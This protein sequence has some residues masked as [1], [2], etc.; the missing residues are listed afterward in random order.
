MYFLVK[1]ADRCRHVIFFQKLSK[2]KKEGQLFF[3]SFNNRVSNMLIYVLWAYL[4]KY[5]KMLTS[6]RPTAFWKHNG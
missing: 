2:D 3:V 5:K 4:D 6:T 1:Y